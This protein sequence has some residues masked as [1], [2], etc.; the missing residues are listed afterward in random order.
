MSFFLLVRLFLQ[1]GLE[2]PEG[3]GVQV[4]QWVPLAQQDHAHP[5]NPTATEHGIVSN[6]G[7]CVKEKLEYWNNNNPNLC[8]VSTKHAYH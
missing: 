2:V 1:Q 6:W 4:N 3:Q 7:E 5:V 8:Y